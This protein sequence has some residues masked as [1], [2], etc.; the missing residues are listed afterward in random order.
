MALT[1]PRVPIVKWKY[2]RKFGGGCFFW[3]TL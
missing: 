1:F 2:S 3:N